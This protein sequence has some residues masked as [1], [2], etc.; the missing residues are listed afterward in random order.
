MTSSHNP[1]CG[2]VLRMLLSSQKYVGSLKMVTLHNYP[3]AYLFSSCTAMRRLLQSLVLHHSSTS[4]NCW[5]IIASRLRCSCICRQVLCCSG[6]ICYCENLPALP[7]D[8]GEI[9]SIH[10]AAAVVAL[11]AVLLNYCYYPNNLQSMVLLK[12]NRMS[13]SHSV[14]TVT[15][16]PL[17]QKTSA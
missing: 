1:E 3:P 4:L 16:C 2:A 6:G 13:F 17:S 9:S 10:Y 11:F 15:V 14:I 5:A 12:P 8:A 7:L